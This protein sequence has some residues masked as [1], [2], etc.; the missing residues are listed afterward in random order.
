MTNPNLD[1]AETLAAAKELLVEAFGFDPATADQVVAQANAEMEAE[2]A[3]NEGWVADQYRTD[4]TF[5]DAWNLPSIRLDMDDEK[6]T[7]MMKN[8]LMLMMTFDEPPV[9][10][11]LVGKGIE[12]EWVKKDAP[13]WLER[14]VAAQMFDLTRDRFAIAPFVTAVRRNF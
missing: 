13:W 10:P 4:L 7:R 5:A 3:G 11:V 9:V 12:M 2:E 14:F 1:I 6:L 8:T